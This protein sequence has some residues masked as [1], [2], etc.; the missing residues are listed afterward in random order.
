MTTHK[1]HSLTEFL[2]AAHIKEF[3]LLPDGS[4]MVF[5]RDS[6]ETGTA[7]VFRIGAD[8]GEPVRLTDVF[9]PKLQ[10][11]PLAQHRAEPKGNI[12]VTDERVFFTSSRYHQAIN[13]IFSVELDGTDLRQHTF[14]DAV[15]ET[16]PAVSP[17]G[18]RLAYF[19]RTTRG[20]KVFLLDL[21][22]AAAWP[23]MLSSGDQTERFPVWSPD[24]RS[25]AFEREGD[26]WLRELATG[27][28]RRLVGASWTKVTNPVFSP[29]STR[30][31]VSAD[32]S[33]FSQIAVVDIATGGLTGLTRV[34][35]EHADAAWSP[36]GTSIA[37]TFTDGV[38]L[39]NQVGLLS[40]DGNGDLVTLTGGTAMRGKPQ[41]SVDGDSVYYLE[42]ASNRVHDI[43]VVPVAGGT[44][45]QLT[46]SMGSLDP[47]HLSVAE[48]AW[49]PAE[50]SLPIR[51]LVFKP[52]DFDPEKK[53]PVVVALHG[54]PGSW[55]H[56][57]SILW[58]WVISRGV[59]LVAP[60][61]RGT[62]GLGAAFHDLHVG[63]MGG[64]E[65]T[66]IMGVLDLIAE[67]PYVDPHRKAT[68]G[69]SG[70]GYMSFLIATRA[71]QVFDA[72]VIRAPVSAW[73]W[74]AMDRFT[75]QAR[76]AT[77][78]R[79]P[80]RAREEMGG[81]YSEIP[82]RYHER[83]P[84]NF[85]EKVTVPQLLMA[86]RRDGSVPINE[87]RRWVARMEELGKGDL[88]DYVEYPDD[89]HSL[90][91]YRSTMHDQGERIVKFLA[92]HLDA[93]Q[94]SEDVRP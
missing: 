22:T 89:D 15:I 30:V 91:R 47:D 40:A 64:V 33:G 69:G 38:G 74:I 34:P 26:T 46:F 35:R 82:D 71:P 3:A 87:S 19:T 49:Y 32:E 37:L 6:L 93:P 44:P 94:L 16:S 65:F 48:E 86:A 11:S 81:S 85:V 50:D 31:L 78:T 52:N 54:H 41:F 25:I 43:W 21:D 24:G 12:V 20:T 42:G 75:G 67:L 79:D 51:T 59:V 36:D 4:G 63:D 5:V 68:W 18:S 57:M 53:Y 2:S 76:Y 66:D 84:L 7:E 17:D 14:H 60:N 72:Q 73:K 39:S 8:G 55:N 62:K 23:E 45:R 9:H 83:S 90:L 29:D 58:Q 27:A 1:S 77:A 10:T 28:E 92:D 80:Q 88:V 70:G 13:N 56:T 61:P